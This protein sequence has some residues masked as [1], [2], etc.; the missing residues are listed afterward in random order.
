M[1]VA[2]DL[3]A[4]PPESAAPPATEPPLTWTSRRLVPFRVLLIAGLAVAGAALLLGLGASA[5]R[6]RDLAALDRE[7]SSLASPA[8]ELTWAAQPVKRAVRMS[9]V[10]YHQAVVRSRLATQWTLGDTL[11]RVM[12]GGGALLAA[13]AVLW[14]LARRARI[15]PP[16]LPAGP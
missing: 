12:L 14:Q 3:A 5:S 10:A 4:P 2:P 13:G 11:P 9:L 8:A 15:V 1:T 7:L 16:R 6:R